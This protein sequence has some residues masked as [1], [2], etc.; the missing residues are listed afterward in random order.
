[1]LR[2]TRSPARFAAAAKARSPLPPVERFTNREGLGVEGVIDG[3]MLVAG[4]PA[5]LAD[6]AMNLPADLEAARR[7]PRREARPRSRRA[8]T[9]EPPRCS[10]WR[11]P[12]SAPPS[13]LSV[14]GNALRLRRFGAYGCLAP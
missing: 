8:G 5:L 10:S 1:M 12:S 11:T 9:G 4:R 3:H 13:S 14:V 7:G 2:S 6:W